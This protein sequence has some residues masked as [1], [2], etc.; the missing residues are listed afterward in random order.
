MSLLIALT[1][2]FATA[3]SVTAVGLVFIDGLAALRSGLHAP[4][5]AAERVT[6]RAQ[7]RRGFTP[8]DLG[9]DP[10]HWPSEKPRRAVDLP[11]LDWPST[12]WPDDDFRRASTAGAPTT[13]TPPTVAPPTV[14]P[15]TVAPAGELAPKPKATKKK[16]DKDG[17]ARIPASPPT[18]TPAE[19]RALIKAEGVGG[20]VR[21]LMADGNLSMR[22]AVGIVEN[23]K[24]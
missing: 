19:L 18:L 12:R 11:T 3:A 1:S 24:R 17:N 7:R 20:A 14:T 21:A 6:S 15:T 23:L 2:L 8:L 13:V 9:P 10:T 22:E 4:P 16:R 5:D